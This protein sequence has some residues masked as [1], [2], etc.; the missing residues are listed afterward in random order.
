[1]KKVQQIVW[2]I[3][4]LRVLAEDLYIHAFKAD[5]LQ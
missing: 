5:D 2:D 4:P 3:T 1:M